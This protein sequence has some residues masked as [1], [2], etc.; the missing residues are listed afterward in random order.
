ML[1][2]Y[3]QLYRRLYVMKEEVA[4]VG[5]RNTPTGDRIFEL[6]EAA[7][8]TV[9]DLA[10]EAGISPTTVVQL[11]HG[12]GEPKFS[13]LRKIARAFGLSSVEEL[14]SDPKAKARPLAQQWLDEWAGRHDLSMS[15]EEAFRSRTALASEE[16][17]EARIEAV[18]HQRDLISSALEFHEL[19]P[20]LRRELE[21]SAQDHIYWRRDL[22]KQRDRLR[23][24]RRASEATS[25]D[26]R[27]VSVA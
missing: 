2:L 17:V 23:E 8:W 7:G 16:E 3:L 22:Q 24:Q 1:Q 9:R 26:L 6:R 14:I 5:A 4:V 11:E 27:F 18:N 19:S 10:E 13:T 12:R 20:A 25:D 21:S 15:N